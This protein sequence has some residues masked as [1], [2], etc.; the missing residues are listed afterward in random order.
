M[1]HRMKAILLD[2]NKQVADL[3]WCHSFEGG[4]HWVKEWSQIPATGCGGDLPSMWGSWFGGG[5][6]CSEL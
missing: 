2:E 5:R 6:D 4:Q 3:D 1:E